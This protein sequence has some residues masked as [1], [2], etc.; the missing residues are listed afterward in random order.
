MDIVKSYTMQM[1]QSENNT[2]LL[3]LLILW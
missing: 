1:N 3:L 2:V